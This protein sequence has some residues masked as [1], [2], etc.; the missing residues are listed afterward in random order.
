M[1]PRIR[2]P[3]TLWYAPRASAGTV[4]ARAALSPLS[5][6]YRA[7]AALHRGLYDA[8]VLRA[9]AAPA[10]VVAVGNVVAG[11]AGKTPVVRALAQLAISHGVK[12]AILSRGY[13]ATIDPTGVRV[14]QPDGSLADA[15]RCGDEPRLLAQALPDVQVYAG[16]D[17]AALAERA[18][19]EGGAQLLLLD[20]GMQHHRLRKDALVAVVRAPHPFGNAQLLPAGPLREPASALRRADAVVV[21]GASPGVIPEEIL[22]AG[23]SRERVWTAALTPSGLSVVPSGEALSLQRLHGAR[24]VALAGIGRPG[25]LAETLRECGAEVAEL[26]AVPDHAPVG[27]E[28]WREVAERVRRHGATAVVVTEKDAVKLLAPPLLPVPV[29]SLAAALTFHAPEATARLWSI[30]WPQ[31]GNGG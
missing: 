13:G 10:R 17:R 31:G 2:T 26:V 4:L 18:V 22:R 7:G 21:L 23:V 1:A 12:T 3:E 16:P 15:H 9:L 29:W 6:A 24:V 25:A 8:G 11:G 28:R 27:A 30:L 20:D 14:R 5:L 19:R